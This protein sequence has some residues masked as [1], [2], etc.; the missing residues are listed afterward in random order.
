[1]LSLTTLLLSGCS[2]VPGSGTDA[3]S[4]PAPPDPDAH[5][6]ADMSPPALEDVLYPPSLQVSQDGAQLAAMHGNQ[7]LIWDEAAGGAPSE[8]IGE[9]TNPA[10]MGSLA[11]T[12]DFSQFVYREADDAV[13]VVSRDGHFE[14]IEL[15]TWHEN[16]RVVR[17][18]ISP[19]GDRLAVRGSSG[20]IVVYSLADH[21]L[22]MQLAACTDSPGDMSFSPDSSK[23]F[24]ASRNDAATVWDLE[25]EETVL[26]LQPDEVYYTHGAWSHDGS[27]LAVSASTVSVRSEAEWNLSLVDTSQ[28]EVTDTYPQFSPTSTM[29]FPDDDELLVANG[30]TSIQ[31]WSLDGMPEEVTTGVPTDQA[32]IAPDG[33]TAYIADRQT[34]IGFDLESAQRSVTYDIPAFECSALERRSLYQ[35]C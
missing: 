12:P 20:A 10:G 1:M 14:T 15:Q 18:E 31:R 26:E 25:T 29:F 2:L 11:A 13:T 35:E 24:A 7:I 33:T 21:N 30:S 22:Q 27:R 23:L 9:A 17:V 32:H 28:W 5:E 19:D 34:L 3:H 6:I 16:E 4:C 8:T